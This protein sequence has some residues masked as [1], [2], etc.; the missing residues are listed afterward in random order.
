MYKRSPSYKLSSCFACL[1]S[2]IIEHYNIDG[3]QLMKCVSCGFEFVETIPSESDLFKY[4]QECYLDNGKFKDKVRNRRWLKYKIFSYYI[5]HLCKN[6]KTIKLLDIGCN[7]GDIQ[8]A[9]NREPKFDAEGI[10]FSGQAVSFA[11]TRGLKVS[12]GRLEDQKYPKETFD[13]ITA[14][15]VIEHTYNPE[16][17]MVEIKRILKKGGYFFAVMPCLSHYKAKINGKNWK[18]Y[19]PPEHLWYFTID[20]LREFGNRLGFKIK[21]CHCIYHR[22]HVFWLI[23]KT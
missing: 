3:Y 17:T 19:T 20:S 14:Y 6:S 21:F 5:K 11:K 10:D 18:Y 1:G 16:R 13:F 23:Q 4:Y 7:Q 2:N 15:H 12:Q 8:Y 9:V 22:A